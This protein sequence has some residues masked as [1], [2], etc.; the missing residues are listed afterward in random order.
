MLKLTAMTIQD[1]IFCQIVAGKLPSTKVYEDKEVLAF[2]SIEAINPGHTLVIPKKHVEEFQ[3]LG[4]DAYSKLMDAVRKVA[5]ALKKTYSPKRVGLLVQGFEVAHGHI[6]VV[7][8]NEA[9]DVTSKKLL[10][11][12][13]L[14]PT[15]EDM[16]CESR[17]ITDNFS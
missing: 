1:C 11:G 12:T 4:E 5:K 15:P 10:E 13:A 9:T 6:H 2:L 8:L 3:D 7:P 14:H 17:K 16:E